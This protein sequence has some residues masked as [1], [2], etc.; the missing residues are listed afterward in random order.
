MCPYKS[1]ESQAQRQF[2]WQIIFKE[3][4]I[5]IFMISNLMSVLVSFFFSFLLNVFNVASNS[6]LRKKLFEV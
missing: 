2:A 5:F 6:F 3:T 1:Q 4:A